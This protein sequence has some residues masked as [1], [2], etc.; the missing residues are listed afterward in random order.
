MNRADTASGT[1]YTTGSGRCGAARSK[2]VPPEITS[3]TNSSVNQGQTM[4]KQETEM[5]VESAL[6]FAAWAGVFMVGAG[7]FGVIGALFW[8]FD[9]RQVQERDE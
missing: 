9:P 2:P 3:A 5:S 4:K 1:T 6:Y 8:A 7:V